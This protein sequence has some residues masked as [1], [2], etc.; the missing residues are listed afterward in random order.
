MFN[1][2]DRVYYTYE[3]CLGIITG[4]K[5][6]FRNSFQWEVKFGERDY[7]YIRQEHLVLYEQDEDPWNRLLNGR[8]GNET[9]LQK[10]LSSVRLSGRLTNIFYSMMTG[11]AQFFPHQFKPVLKFIESINGNLLIADE[12]GLGKTVEALYIWKEL[13]ARKEAKKLLIITPATLRVKWQ[14]DAEHFF[15]I[16]AVIQN[17]NEFYNDIV[18]SSMPSHRNEEKIWILSLQGIRYKYA[19]DVPEDD[20][21]S[22]AQLFKLLDNE[23]YQNFFDL[24]I[25]DEAH[26]LR[27]SETAS[28]KTAE[29]IRNISKNMVLL[30]A[31]PIQTNSDNL[32]NLLR[33][34]SPEEYNDKTTFGEMLKKNTLLVKLSNNIRNINSI[35]DTEIE[36]YIKNISSLDKIKYKFIIDF[37][38]ENKYKLRND[39]NIQ[40]KLINILSNYYFYNQCFSRTR[41]CDTTIKTASRFAYWRPFHLN[42]IELNIYKNVKQYLENIGYGRK[43]IEI[44]TLITRLRQ[45]TSSIPA[46]IKYWKEKDSIPESVWANVTP[47]SDED[48]YYEDKEESKQNNIGE[49]IDNIS[50]SIDIHELINNDTKYEE[51]LNIINGIDKNEKIIIFSFYRYTVE[52]ICNRLNN[53]GFNSIKLW[54][55][56]GGKENKIEKEQIMAKFENDPSI[57]ILVS[58]EVGSEGVDL[59]FSGYEINYDLPWN[60][61][62]LEQRIGRIDRIGQIRDRISIFNL[63]CKD[64]IE[65]RVMERL[66]ERIDIFTSSIGEIEQIIGEKINQ[67]SIE[68]FNPNLTEEQQE[69]KI[70]ATFKA[71]E[72]EKQQKDILEERSGVLNAQ[73]QEVIMRNINISEKNKRYLTKDELFIFI[74]NSLYNSFPQ[75]EIRNVTSSSFNLSMDNNAYHDFSDFINKKNIKSISRIR[76]NKSIL[77]NFETNNEKK[78][79]RQE[80]YDFIDSNH[81]LIKWLAEKENKNLN[82]TGCASLHFQNCKNITPGI[83]LFIIQEWIIEGYR[84]ADELHF[85]FISLK[86]NECIV[87][88]EAENIFMDNIFKCNKIPESIL[89]KYNINDNIKLSKEKII[90]K[91][92]L[93]YENFVSNF[94]EQHK[95]TVSQQKEY[96]T[97][98][99]KRQSNELS[100]LIAKYEYEGRN[101]SVI[102][103]KKT[104]LENIKSV[105]ESQMYELDEKMK[106]KDSMKEIAIGIILAGEYDE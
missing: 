3:K 65:D 89:S 56:K 100:E 6:P 81:P 12:V 104:R 31:T 70:E 13:V 43:P 78:Y 49:D 80:N 101:E 24:V 14:E 20:K 45:L 60:P 61:M 37:Y 105:Y 74:I 99:Y 64:T 47:D 67:L 62:R 4:E 87:E 94:E 32:F 11:T 40:V 106:I 30:S 57:R 26:Y 93:L 86:N 73:F 58:T 19:S 91:M 54:G 102:K 77:C 35:T 50:T 42:E 79:R 18:N 84:K 66:Y 75:T 44:F 34:L 59:Q 9:D 17:C 2:G 82:Y 92:S 36:G 21:S 10:Y 63:S 23:K 15:G 103:G 71:I 85:I 96:S 52:Y 69:R 7:K 76:P 25:I 22:K 98:L 83:Y 53:D 38:Y 51:L 27:N 29:F 68:L 97:I 39:V 46:A 33:L 28:F 88:E 90:N 72:I 8:L 1:N 5:R 95:I 48:D 41:K 16:G 55:S